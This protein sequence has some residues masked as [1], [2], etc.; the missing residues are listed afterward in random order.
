M[1]KYKAGDKFVIEI[2]SVIHG[3][4]ICYKTNI[5]GNGRYLDAEQLDKLEQIEEIADDMTAEEAW[6]IAKKISEMEDSEIMESILEGD[7]LNPIRAVLYNFTP[8]QVKSKI[9][10]WESEKEIKVGDVVYYQ[11]N[12][13]EE[14][15]VIADDNKFVWV[16]SHASRVQNILK[17]DLHKTGQHIDIQSVFKLIGG[18][19]E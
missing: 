17:E 12:D 7:A 5:I 9:E 4:D 19:D 15:L 13:N 8:H 2:K 3:D 14:F 11:N 6:E 1:S 10:A 16:Y 18:S